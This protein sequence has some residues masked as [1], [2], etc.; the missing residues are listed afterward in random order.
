[1]KDF[2]KFLGKTLFSNANILN[3]KKRKFYQSLIVVTLSL[4]FAILPVFVYTVSVK[5]SSILTKNSNGSLDVSLSLFS[6]FLQEDP[7]ASV[8]VNEK[9]EFEVTG[10]SEKSFY[11]GE[12]HLLTV[13]VMNESDDIETIK[14]YYNDGITDGLPTETPK[15]FIAISKTKM[16][17][18]IFA[19][20]AKNE[21]YEDNISVKKNAS[22]TSN[23]VGM[24]RDYKN[25]DFATYY[26][27]EVGGEDY[28]FNAWKTALNK[29]YKSYK[30]NS[31]F[32]SCFVYTGLNVA[33]IV[34]MA[35]VLM[36]LT[37]I[38]SASCEKMTF[39][40][41]LN[42]INWAS[43][44]PSLI[45]LIIGFLITNLAA[46]AFIICMSIRAIALRIKAT[47]A[48]KY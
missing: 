29:M 7:S 36:I 32:Y 40:E 23:Y 30:L 19:G 16:Y 3:G 8:I 4:I 10:F 15:S 12:K 35:L 24:G 31:L 39:V 33:I 13:K 44:C 6:K 45:S 43:L 2:F 17:I 14:K 46:V 1:M 18:Y 48:P 22:Y 20:D 34:T 9:G 38:R 27:N 26:K 28:C 42:C 37:K 47:Q 5:G 41:S 11:S 21:M 25:Q